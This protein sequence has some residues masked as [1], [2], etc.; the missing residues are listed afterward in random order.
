MDIF[1]LVLAS[2]FLLVGLIGC[3]VPVLPGPPLSYIGL[4]LLHFTS[5]I[6]ISTTTLLWIAFFTIVVTVLDYIVPIIGTKKL[7]GSKY[8]Q[9]GATIGL[10]I[11]LFFSPFGIIIGPF[12]G[13]MIGELSY[14]RT[15]NEALKSALGSFV[16]FLIGTFA[17][18][19]VSGAISYVFIVEIWNKFSS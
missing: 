4:L 1:L 14:G 11:G 13:A 2:F 7:G 18:L 15:T 9:W 19:V 12:A 3:V 6:D 8:G 17:K 5:W 16:G 10:L